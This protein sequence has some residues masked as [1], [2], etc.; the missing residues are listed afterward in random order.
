MTHRQPNGDEISGFIDYEESLRNSIME[1]DEGATDWYE[2]FKG[3]KRIKPTKDDLGLGC[4]HAK[5][6][7]KQ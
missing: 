6:N 7:E 3:S 2:I 1:F 4:S 5:Q